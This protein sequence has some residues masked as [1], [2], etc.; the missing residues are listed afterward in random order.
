V[1]RAVLRRLFVPEGAEA[2]AEV[3]V[4]RVALVFK[5]LDGLLELIGGVILLVVRPEQI[6]GLADFL[7]RGELQEDPRDFVATHVLAASNAFS[8]H[9]SLAFWS[10]LYLLSHALVK[11][12]LVWAVIRDRLWAYPWMIVFL[13]AFIVYQVFAMAVHFSIG[14]LLLTILDVVVCWLTYR[15]YRRLRRQRAT[16]AARGA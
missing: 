8:S 2:G 9:G 10:A 12:V 5:G 15:E 13:L 7:T 6:Q 3:L 16:V 1:I 4:F 14:L 11:I